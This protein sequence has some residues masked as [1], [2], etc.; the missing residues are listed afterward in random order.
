MIYVT[1][2]LHGDIDRLKTPEIKKLKKRDTL[3]V[4]G[5]FGFVWDG[6]KK[7]QKILKWLGKRRYD[8]LFIEGTH[9]NYQLLK[10]YPEEEWCGG[11]T[12]LISGRL[13]WLCRG[14]V[15]E[16]E[17]KKIF[18]FGG[19]VSADREARAEQNT[20]WPEEA[21]SEADRERALENLARHGFEVDHICTHEGPGQLVRFLDLEQNEVD[22]TEAF[23]EELSSQVR[24]R[25]WLFGARHLDRSIGPKAAAVYR[26]VLPLD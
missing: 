16:I 24:Y 18:C 13:R 3:I 4:L 1:G 5:D 22:D 6:S 25:R 2:D 7:E 10:N 14:E 11:R 17:G 21:A 20:W 26:R 15:F 8:L 19:G 9:D 23:L 12:R